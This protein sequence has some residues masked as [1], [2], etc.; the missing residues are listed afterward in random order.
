MRRTY[1]FITVLAVLL[2]FAA[3]FLLRQPRPAR[4]RPVVN[5][6]LVLQSIRQVAKLTTAEYGLADIVS[7]SQEMPWYARDKQVIVIADG[8]VQAGVDLDDGTTCRVSGSASNR[9]IR[10]FLPP[11]RILSTDVNYR[12]FLDVGKLTPED[13]TWILVHGK[14]LI[15]DKAIRFG[16]LS[17]AEAHAVAFLTAF[18]SALDPGAEVS[19]VVK[20]K[21]PAN[22]EPP[23]AGGTDSDSP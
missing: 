5:D 7:F 14:R 12:Y 9:T 10:L 16:V 18:V 13:R 17:K 6:A 20:G 22:A 21:R 3:G 11:A 19:V 15:R 8:V 1:T 2:A 23:T 4:E